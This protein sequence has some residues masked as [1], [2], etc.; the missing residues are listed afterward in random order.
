[1]SMDVLT[2]ASNVPF[3]FASI[4]QGGWL[5]ELF[6]QLVGPD[7]VDGGSVHTQGP[8]TIVSG[9]TVYEAGALRPLAVEQSPNRVVSR[10]ALESSG[11]ELESVWTHDPGS[12]LVERQDRLL[13]TGT[14]PFRFRRF[15]SRLALQRGDVELYTQ[16][17]VWAGEGHGRWVSLHAGSVHLGCEGGRT[18]QLSAPLMAVRFQGTDRGLVLHLVPCGNWAIRATARPVAQGSPVTVLEAGVADDALDE[19]LQPGD[20][21]DGPRLLMTALVA[22]SP[23]RSAASLHRFLLAREFAEAKRTAPVM[24]NTWLDLFDYLDVERLRRQIPVLTELGVD[25]LE[26]DAGW[27][28]R[29]GINEWH[30]SVGDWTENPSRSFYGRMAEFADEVR[31]AGLAFGLFMEPE[32][33]GSGA[34]VRL[35]HPEW[36][37]GRG[38][39]FDLEHADVYA[40]VRD[41]VLRVLDTYDA[42]WLRIDLNS[43]LGWDES[44][45]ELRRYTEK[46][47]EL[48]R[49]VRAAR[50]NVFI[51]QCA[52]GGMRYDLNILAHGD[53][54]Y[55]TDTQNP[56]D[57]IRVSEGTM[58]RALPGRSSRVVALR[59]LGTS[60][61][62]HPVDPEN[63]PDTLASPPAAGWQPAQYPEAYDLDFVA[64]VAM[65]GV[66]AISGDPSSLSAANRE[67][68]RRHIRF[69]K[70]IQPWVMGS[71]ATLLTEPKPVHDRSG[72][73]VFQY[74]AEDGVHLVFA[75]RLQDA[76]ARRLIPLV[77]L[78]PETDYHIELHPEGV[79]RSVSGQDLMSRGLDLTLPKPAGAVVCVLR[80]FTGEAL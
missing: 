47:L 17:G 43:H 77:D 51:E 41:E 67:K 33:A 25:L 26:V 16:R 57:L 79:A 75:F 6:G 21:Y 71:A 69:Y 66:M 3:R 45:A 76:A 31:A 56:V 62:G 9:S 22:G 60:F 5:S 65:L 18:T 44:G 42:R 10:F 35:D 70:Q 19:T 1:M 63:M 78:D 15:W 61:P 38:S 11:V 37:V 29:G 40:H 12:G 59:T 73:S 53:G 74:H 64:I 27:Y 7:G 28:G 13:N 34:Q 4:E 8:A 39:R 30:D 32:T 54:Y 49:E 23:E 2:R 36:F 52:S 48:F 20:H 46:L 80:P 14:E 50:P 72:W 58:L 24:F 55:L 68:L